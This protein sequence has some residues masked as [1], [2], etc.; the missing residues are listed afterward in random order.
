[1]SLSFRRL[2]LP[3]LVGF[4]LFGILTGL[5]VV[6]GRIL[7]TWLGWVMFVFGLAC[8]AGPAGLLG[9][10]AVMR[11]CWWPESGW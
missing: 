6:V 3:T 11:G 5:A 9:L 10:L 4:A 7:P 8:L 2:F 1:M